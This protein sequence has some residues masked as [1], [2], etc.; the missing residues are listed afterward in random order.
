[1]RDG[2]IYGM[3]SDAV[4]VVFNQAT[5]LPTYTSKHLFTSLSINLYTNL[6]IY[7]PIYLPSYLPTYLL[8]GG[9]GGGVVAV[10][11]LD[12]HGGGDVHI[13]R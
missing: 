8:T 3:V 11:V 9:V 1:M 2:W 4:S 7:L 6:S 12:G 5:N 13:R 10:P